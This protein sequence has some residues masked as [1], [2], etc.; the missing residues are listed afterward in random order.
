[1][2]NDSILAS[3]DIK[4][5]REISSQLESNINSVKQIIYEKPHLIS[6][7]LEL[8]EELRENGLDDKSLVLNCVRYTTSHIWQSLLER[9]L[10]NRE[11]E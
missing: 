6:K 4:D 10:F 2:K 8:E 7:L 5:L 9:E 1:M 3:L 11:N